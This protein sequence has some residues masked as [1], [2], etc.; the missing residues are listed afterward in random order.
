MQSTRVF[1]SNV[2]LFLGFLYFLVISQLFIIF[3]SQNSKITRRCRSNYILSNSLG[4]VCLFIY[5]YTH[6][7]VT[8]KQNYSLSGQRQRNNLCFIFI[9]SFFSV[10]L[11]S[12]LS[13]SFFFLLPS[14]NRESTLERATAGNM[15]ADLQ[16]IC[17]RTD[18]DTRSER[19]REREREAREVQMKTVSS[20]Y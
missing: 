10:T 18:A 6:I 4:S 3:Y 19:G 7:R 11:F 2:D 16:L 20:Y 12:V 14:S 5:T 15:R 9:L 1:G 8:T 17:H 13:P